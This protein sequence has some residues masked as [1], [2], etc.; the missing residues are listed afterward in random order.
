MKTK[1]NINRKKL[2]DTE[3]DNYQ[4]FD[5]LYQKYMSTAK[6]FYKGK[7]F[8]GGA[9]AA[10]VAVVAIMVYLYLHNI[11]N[12]DT[13]AMKTQ[14]S[15][16]VASA[17]LPFINPPMKGIDVPFESYKIKASKG[18]EIIYKTGSKLKIPANCFVDENGNTI[19]GEVEIRYR[20]FHDVVDFFVS[21]IPMTYDS[22][23]TTYT[24]ESAGMME[25]QGYLNNKPIAMANGKSIDVKMQS[26]YKGTHYNLYNLDTVARNWTYV[27]KDK[28]VAG[29]QLPVAGKKSDDNAVEGSELESSRSKGA[30]EMGD[31]TSFITICPAEEKLE[32]LQKEELPIQPVKPV[33]AKEE[34]YT[35]NIDVNGKE[36]P[37]LAIYKD[38]LF[39][40]H[41]KHS[42]FDPELYEIQWDDALLKKLEGDNN[43]ELTLSSGSSNGDNIKKV[44]SVYPV[45]EGKQYEEAK[46]IYDKKFQEYTQ[47]I[48]ARK[49]EEKP[50]KED[51]EKQKQEA[52]AKWEAQQEDLLAQSQ[53]N[54][55]VSR[56][57]SINGFG[58]YNC[59]SPQRFPIGANLSPFTMADKE[60]KE[61]KSQFGSNNILSYSSTTQIYYPACLVEKGRN[62]LFNFN[63]KF[64]PK[65]ENI[66]WQ[67]LPDNNLAIFKPEDFKQINKTTGDYTFK[68]D[69]IQ[70]E[71]V[72]QMKEV[73]GI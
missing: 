56:E 43:Y 32:K 58:F 28:V 19:T 2:S 48:E 63:G 49:T 47:K 70:I 54:N 13:T 6:P 21:G 67:T 22:A 3:I 59:D 68:M 29:C 73:L 4:D 42:D 18:G 46:K 41:P 62:A 64:N 27:G 50:L 14:D 25:I 37:E 10:T 36:F 66:L 8:W 34:N 35:F 39:E 26:N 30:D 20:E 11:K 7:W 57:F 51:V 53:L 72:E 60:G 31:G 52:I 61:L 55:L 65:T 40:I 33:K 38:V 71:S 9:G 17:E 12:T 16:A 1:F 5:K 24:F 45:F 23:G 69:V 44:F 15:V